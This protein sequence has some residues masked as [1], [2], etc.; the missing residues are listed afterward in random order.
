LIIG[1]NID[2]SV[3]R[4]KGSGRPLQSIESR[5]MVLASLFF[6]NAVIAFEEDTPYDLIRFIQPDILVKGS[7]YKESEIVGAD[8]VKS[9]K[10]MVTTLPFLEGYSTSSI[11]KKILRNNQIKE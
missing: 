11:E 1:L 7:D 8:V 4:R 3:Q 2:E 9:K 10:G 5:F 6:V